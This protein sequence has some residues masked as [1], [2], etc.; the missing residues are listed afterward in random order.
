[1]MLKTLTMS[2]ILSFQPDS[3]GWE[4]SRPYLHKKLKVIDFFIILCDTY[5]SG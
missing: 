1:M 4:R 3:G 2:I 5:N